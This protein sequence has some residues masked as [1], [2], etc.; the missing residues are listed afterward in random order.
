M[1][2]LTRAAVHGPCSHLRDSE[3]QDRATLRAIVALLDRPQWGPDTL[4]AIAEALRAA[5]YRIRDAE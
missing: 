4:D 1:A 3:K 5:G 2:A